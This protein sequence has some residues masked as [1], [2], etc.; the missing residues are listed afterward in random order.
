MILYEE[1]KGGCCVGSQIHGEGVMGNAC[2]CVCM[3]DSYSYY[4]SVLN[5]WCNVNDNMCT[6]RLVVLHV[7]ESKTWP[8]TWIAESFHWLIV[9][10]MDV[11]VL[12]EIVW[13]NHILG[14]MQL[15]AQLGLVLI[16]GLYSQLGG[17]F[18]GCAYIHKQSHISFKNICQFTQLLQDSS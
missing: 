1:A 2:F 5:C 3:N 7:K 9:C 18:I 13:D 15:T 17:H 6:C 11:R 4:G 10:S 16:E 14:C 8:K 12:W